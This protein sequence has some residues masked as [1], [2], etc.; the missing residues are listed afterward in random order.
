MRI[1]A[2][3]IIECIL[4]SKN[5]TAKSLSEKIGLDRPQAIY[6]IQKLKTKNITSK[7]ADKIISVYPDINRTWL[8]TGEG[9]MSNNKDLPKKSFIKGVPYYNVDFMAGFDIMIN[10]KTITPEFL[11]D[12]KTYNEATCWCNVT[13]H[14][15]E[16][17]INN[18]DIIA[19]K[20]INDI[21]FLPLGE[22]YAIV[23]KND[24]RTI[25]RIGKGDTPDSY[26]LIPANKSLEYSPQQI[27][28]KM[29]RF[30]YQVLG[31]AKRF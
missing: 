2:K 30:V 26:T 16:P 12:F 27:P 15:M 8:L 23:T 1:N 7:M 19:I 18:G 20:K 25:K 5:I 31:C 28:I 21:S 6:D 4:T 22:I 10:D 24:M 14:S 11:I 13:G 17:E 29:I 3:E 9:D